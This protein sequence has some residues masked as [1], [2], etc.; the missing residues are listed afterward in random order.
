MT[1]FAKVWD[2]KRYQ[3]IALIL[4]NDENGGHE[5]KVYF[6]PQG[7]GISSFVMAWPKDSEIKADKVFSE[8][9]MK[10]AIEVVDKFMAYSAGGQMQ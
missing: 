2:V 8:M 9:V 4:Q 7:H 10:D 6:Q 1:R 3:Q 5:I